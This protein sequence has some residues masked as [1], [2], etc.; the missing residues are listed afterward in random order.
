MRLMF[1]IQLQPH[2]HIPL[3]IQ[4][5]D[6]LRALIYAGDLRPG[7]RIVSSRELAVQLRVHRT[8][9]ANAFDELVAEGLIEGKVGAGTFISKTLPER[10]F[11]PPPLPGPSGPL[12][13]E[14]LFADERADDSLSRLMPKVSDDTIAFVTAQA[15][16]EFFPV[17]EVRR[18]VS[19]VLGREG[20]KILQLGSSDGY[21]PLK[22]VLLKLLRDDGISAKP[23][24]LLV[25]DGCQQSLDLLAKAFLR[26][27]D[28]VLLE[29]PA[30]P[31]AMGIFSGARVRCLVAPVATDGERLGYSGID[32]GAVEA[33][34]QQNRVKMILVTPDFQNPTGTTLPANERR[35]L[36]DIA[37]HFQVPVV[38]DHIYARLRMRG[39]PVP[40][41]KALDRSGIVIQIDSFSKIAFPGLRV[42]WCV[43]P[44][45]V[46]ERLRQVK[47]ASDL[48][49]DQ[50]AQ[51]TLAEFVRRRF[52]EKHLAKMLRVYR[53]R[54][55]ALLETLGRLMPAGTTWT[56]VEG[57]MS[58]WVT[59]PPGLDAA[60]LLIHAR[61]RGLSFMP[62]RYFYLQDP[63]PNTLRLGFAGLDERRIVR[64][65]AMLAEE[66]AVQMRTRE[67][68]AR[69]EMPPA[70]E[71][72]SRVALV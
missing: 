49:T 29:N 60:E 55:S 24:Q 71:E 64:G 31:G 11:T 26:P 17:A 7:D 33:V 14:A 38:E 43:G 10:A 34:L 22:E 69:R 41:L 6:Q 63:Q 72:R 47:Q 35:K 44:E 68:G 46:I 15:A 59:L 67:R 4:L 50:L 54:L 25:T 42:G 18:C 20:R 30:Y 8:T 39:E 23:S 28:A 21:G 9:V 58:V 51:A 36:L 65:V 12:R 62:G 61:Q 57:G 66:L 56:N 32:L 70:E 53:G 13:W 5:R 37:A 3:Y 16:E 48:H 1:P 19:G 27:G 2:S 40:S 52:L 45:R